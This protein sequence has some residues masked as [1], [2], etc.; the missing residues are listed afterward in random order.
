MA[1]RK[2]TSEPSC[3]N[4][5]GRDGACAGDVCTPCGSMQVGEQ[6]RALRFMLVVTACLLINAANPVV[7]LVAAE[8]AG[9]ASRAP[10]GAEDDEWERASALE[11]ARSRWDALRPVEAADPLSRVE[12]FC[13]DAQRIRVPDLCGAHTSASHV[14]RVDVLP[15]THGG[16]TDAVCTD[17]DRPY[18]VALGHGFGQWL[19]S[20][21]AWC[22]SAADV[23][24]AARVHMAL[25]YLEVGGELPVVELCSVGDVGKEGTCVPPRVRKD[26]SG[27]YRLRFEV[28]LVHR[29]RAANAEAATDPGE[30]EGHRF[31]ERRM[32][33]GEGGKRRIWD[34]SWNPGSG[35]LEARLDLRRE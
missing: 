32:C 22:D 25:R 23:L 18:S 21:G 28:C 24:D 2:T 14:F 6:A 29:R 10:G 1:H 34:W 26:S 9:D 19:Q 33:T 7:P 12:S 4:G 13:V 27:W 3:G 31:I 16:V 15:L 20:W 5:M 30:P 17:V 8:A 35:T 11:F